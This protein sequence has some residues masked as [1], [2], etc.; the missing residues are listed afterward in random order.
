MRGTR[1]SSGSAETNTYICSRR[2]TWSS[3]VPATLSIVEQFGVESIRQLCGQFRWCWSHWGRS[4]QGTPSR[5]SRPT[6][7]TSDTVSKGRPQP[8][9][10]EDTHSSEQRRPQAIQAAPD[11]HVRVGEVLGT[12]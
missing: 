3:A 6:S 2:G 4:Q 9:G 12:L 5:P 1:S 7:T 11:R 10:K 8:T